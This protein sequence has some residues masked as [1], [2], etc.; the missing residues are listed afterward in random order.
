MRFDYYAASIPA[1]V[2]HCID[3]IKDTFPGAM[4]FARPVK[5]YTDGLEHP[6][7]GFRLYHGGQNPHPYLVG[8]GEVAARCAEF[9]REV[10]PAHRVARADVAYDF[11]EPGGFDRIVGLIDPIARAAGVKV[12]FMGGPSPGQT[13]GRTMYYGS[14]DSDVRMRVYEKDLEQAA[15]GLGRGPEGWTRCEL[16][17]RPRKERKSAAAKMSEAEMW[18]LSKWSMRAIETVLGVTVPYQPDRSM[19]ES[20]C[21]RALR[22]MLDQ[23]GST[24]RAFVEKYGRKAL[25]ARITEKLIEGS[26]LD[27]RKRVH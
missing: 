14:K 3:A 16:Q 20:T 13:D 10:Y 2:S 24:M 15:K 23:Y 11:I 7:E 1:P 5:P 26:A 6:D 8:T 9:L 27:Q 21:E 22:H 4:L 25:D 19:R 17:T 12:T 18:G